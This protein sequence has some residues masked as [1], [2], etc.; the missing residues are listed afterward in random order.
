MTCFPLKY[1]I[2]DWHQLKDV[3]SNNSR[4]LYI[5]V[6]DLIQNDR[7]TG[8]RIQVLHKAFGVLFACI[9]NAQGSIVSEF[10]N[11]MTLELTTKQI[12]G[13]LKKYGFLVS[14]NPRNHLPGNQIEYLMTLKGL[15]YDKLRILN[16]WHIENGIKNFSGMWS[17]L[18]CRKT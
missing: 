2:S 16:V 11:N 3:K 7:L 5:L 14:Y 1:N 12:I 18:M 4:D 17:H 8:L 10:N 9:L 6:S 13:E 15:G